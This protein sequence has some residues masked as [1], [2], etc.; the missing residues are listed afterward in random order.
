MTL[1]V[2][3]V[4]ILAIIGIIFCPVFTFSIVLFATGHWVLG[5]LC[6]IMSLLRAL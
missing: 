4:T 6:L 2:T 3:T 5:I 1:S